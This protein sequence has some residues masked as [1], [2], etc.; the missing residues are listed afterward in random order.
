MTFRFLSRLTLSAAFIISSSSQAQ[1]VSATKNSPTP[2]KVAARTVAPKPAPPK[3]FPFA[4]PPF[5]SSDNALNV[6]WMNGKAAGAN[7]FV[8]TRGESF[9]DGQGKPI[10]FWGVNLNFAGVFPP[11]NE[12]PQIA[13]RLAKFGF[14][15]VRLHSF[16][17]Y[18]APNGI[19]KQASTGS[20]RPKIPRELDADQL[21]RMDFFINEL[22]KRG[23]YI[24][25]NLHVARK[26]TEGEGVVFAS[27]LPD[28]DKGLNYFDPRLIQLSK[29][30]SRQILTHVNP[31]SGRALKDEPGVC[32]VEVTN[33]NSLL[34]MWLN[35]SIRM[36]NEYSFRLRDRWMSWLRAKY[37]DENTLRRAW[38]EINE[39]LT[40]DNIFA[41][42][43]PANVSN[44]DAPDAR[45]A[46]SANSLG[47]LQLAT[48]GGGVGK[49][50]VESTSGPSVEGFVRPGYTAN[51]QTQG[52]LDWSYQINRD[53]LDL[54]EGQ[55]YT[56]KFWARSDNPRRISVNLWQDR[57]P[58]RFGGFTGYAN[59]TVNWEEYTFTFRP[60][61]PDPGH[62]RLSWNL[63]KYAGN[64]Q[65]GE[66]DLREGG[67][68]AAPTLWSLAHGVPLFEWK[69]TPILRARTDLAEFLGSVEAEN[70]RL[71][72]DFLKKD[73]GVKVPIWHTQAQF[74]GW[75]GVLREADLSDA[76][77]VHAYWKHPNFSGGG[78][79]GTSWKVGNASMTQAAATDPLSAFA[80]LRV[81]GKPFVMTEWNSG[82]PNDFGAETLL[83]SAT[84]AA[85]QD[86]AGVWLFDYHS[87]GAYNRDALTGFFSI[88]THPAKMATATAAALLYR[89][90]NEYS[91]SFPLGDVRPS[92]SENVLSLPRDL[93]WSETA[94]F[95]DGPTATPIIR[96][97][98][99]AGAQRSDS[100]EGRTYVRLRSGG[101]QIQATQTTNRA[102][103]RNLSFASDTGQIVWNG[104]RG[105]FTLDSPRSK[106]AVGF[107]GGT[108]TR[109]SEWRVTM[110]PTHSN[111]GAFSLSS[112]DGREISS[113]QKILLTAV[114]KA[115]NLNMGWN[116]DRSSVGSQW[117]TGPTQVEGLTAFIRI[118]SDLRSARV[119]ALDATGARKVGVG[120][121]LRNGLLTFDISPDYQTVWYEIDGS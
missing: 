62:S 29:D 19:W 89:R 81:K 33:E 46:V 68:I 90:P 74:G 94:A 16:E 35:G 52:N 75:G 70:A 60:I 113:S 24:T 107:L 91:N 2:R 32:A 96:T 101:A 105:L 50:A 76:I 56:L 39:P 116:A 97:W 7:G 4:L 64:V 58:K 57:E 31:Y 72:R 106:V 48:V 43:F 86:W 118:T 40:G 6:A 63:G 120:S 84:Y 93:V 38:T 55:V 47:R 12:A 82:Q 103:S 18:A 3:L 71:M 22:I 36:P 99:E 17:G 121:T 27:Q 8:S 69:S 66:I 109:W 92:D 61:N 119:W 115:E 9:V 11:K 26:T 34:A 100:L 114:G 98:R 49:G 108:S 5:D 53:G 42:P 15:S 25:L 10:R 112:L 102:V 51:L 87:S 44:G 20:S 80:H 77:D 88:D 14:N 41:Q 117:G 110:P 83:M 23:L 59:L 1:T 111:W 73:L 37:V 85:W 104:K 21:D 28:K 13:A 30:F 65:L 67:Q 54:R 78:W 95:A 45:N 79:S